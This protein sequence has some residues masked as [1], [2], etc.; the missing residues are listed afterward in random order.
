MMASLAHWVSHHA[1]TCLTLLV[2]CWPNGRC[3]TLKSM[4]PACCQYAVNA[5]NHEPFAGNSTRGSTRNLPRRLPHAVGLAVAAQ[6]QQSTG[7]S[8]PVS[9][10]QL[11]RQE[12]QPL[13][14]LMSGDSDMQQLLQPNVSWLQTLQ[15]GSRV[16]LYPA[17]VQRSMQD[18][19]REV[20]TMCGG[21]CARCVR[22]SMQA[23]WKREGTG[24]VKQQ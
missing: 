22:R 3:F 10:L 8:H 9:R 1:Q 19:C 23:V 17:C 11:S 16:G 15:V 6:C 2:H 5:A 7:A 14:V 20:C 18:V 13:V 21:K 24:F 4:P 12:P